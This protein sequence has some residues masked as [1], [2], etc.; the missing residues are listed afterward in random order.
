M[1]KPLASAPTVLIPLDRRQLRSSVDRQR[2]LINAVPSLPATIAI[3]TPPISSTELAPKLAQDAFI[4]RSY[5]LRNPAN[6]GQG[7]DGALR[8][9]AAVATDVEGLSQSNLTVGASLALTGKLVKDG[10]QVIVHTGRVMDGIRMAHTNLARTSAGFQS[11]TTGIG[12]GIHT[13]KSHFK[14]I[15]LQVERVGAVGSLA[16]A[17]LSIP[18]LAV[19]AVHKNRAAVTALRSDSATGQEKIAA[20][21]N[22]SYTNAALAYTAVAVPSAI[23]TLATTGRKTSAIT[24]MAV[25]AQSS[26]TYAA[27]DRAS[28]VISPVADATLL[29]ADGLHLYTTLTN[30][31]ATN[32]QR[33]RAGLNVSLD[34]LKVG[35][36][37]L[38][39]T[40]AVR[41][42]YTAAGISQLGFAVYGIVSPEKP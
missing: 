40:R 1:P 9:F 4:S 35:L 14:P 16:L 27:A 2:A 39:Q 19:S 15:L 22:A 28:R 31:Q 30:K 6:V 10:T 17:A 12:K 11:A 29:V 20:V 7:L 24:K 37:T 36:Y 34:A 33:A 21:T 26:R 42:A 18:S 25:K 32:Q 38:P 41:I 5:D 3:D 23:K 8:S 13:A